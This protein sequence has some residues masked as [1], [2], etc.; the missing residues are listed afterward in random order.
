MGKICGRHRN[1]DIDCIKEINKPEDKDNYQ[2][3]LKE[4]KIEMAHE[5]FGG[6]VVPITN[7]IH[8]IFKGHGHYFNELFVESN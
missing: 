1:V 5:P 4:G 6:E 8:E 7:R 3:N 2:N